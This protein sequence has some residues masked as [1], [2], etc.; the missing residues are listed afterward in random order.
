MVVDLKIIVKI[1]SYSPGRLIHRFKMNSRMP[2]KGIGE[3][4]L[5]NLT[6][7]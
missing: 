7:D 2:L 6:G 4:I 5:L 1:S 3:N